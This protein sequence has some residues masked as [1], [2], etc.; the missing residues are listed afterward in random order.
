MDVTPAMLSATSDSLKREATKG[1]P[2]MFTY[3][4]VYVYEPNKQPITFYVYMC[5]C[6]C[7]WAKLACISIVYNSIRIC[8]FHA[9]TS[10]LLSATSDSLKGEAT[11]GEPFMSIF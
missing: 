2:S 4:Y 9:L 10:A 7:I 11:K 5:S 8:L 6:V 3:V 1:E